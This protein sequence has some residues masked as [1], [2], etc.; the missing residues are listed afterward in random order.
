VFQANLKRLSAASPNAASIRHWL[1]QGCQV[2]CSLPEHYSAI[3]AQQTGTVLYLK[4]LP[5]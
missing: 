4:Q 1:N 2:S 5:A 3:A